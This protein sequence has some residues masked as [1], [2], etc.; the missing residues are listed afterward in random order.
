MKN[1]LSI[2]FCLIFIGSLSAQKKG[3]PTTKP[4]DEKKA[5]LKSVANGYLTPL[6]PEKAAEFEVEEKAKKEAVEKTEQQK[7][8]KVSRKFWKRKRK[9]DARQRAK[10]KSQ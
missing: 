9:S 3:N 10:T 4:L 6:S 7:K 1:F 8:E 5:P 2:F